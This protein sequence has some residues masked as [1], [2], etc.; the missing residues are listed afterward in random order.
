MNDNGTSNA[1]VG[2]SRHNHYRAFMDC[3][4]YR[5]FASFLCL[6]ASLV[7]APSAF[8]EKTVIQSQTV[9]G[10]NRLAVTRYAMI[11][12]THT[13]PR[14][15]YW[16]LNGGQI[17]QGL[18]QPGATMQM[19]VHLRNGSWT[20]NTVS[21]GRRPVSLTGNDVTVQWGDNIGVSQQPF[22]IGLQ[23][24]EFEVEYG[25]GAGLVGHVLPDLQ[26]SINLATKQIVIVDPLKPDADQDG[27]PDDQD[28]DDDND[29]IPDAQD[30][31]H[32]DYVPPDTDGDGL[33]DDIDD[34]DDGD[35]IPDNQDPHPKV[36]D[37]I[38]DTDGDGQPDWSDPDDDNDGSPDSQDPEPLNPDVTGPNIPPDGSGL[39]TDGDGIPDYRDS[40]DD[41]DG[42][43]DV[44]DRYP[45]DPTNGGGGGGTPDTPN[46]PPVPPSD[47]GGA[48]AMNQITEGPD[49]LPQIKPPSES[50]VNNI[51]EARGKM[52]LKIQNF[53]LLQ[54]GSI[55]RTNTWSQTLT[56]PH[57]GTMNL[58]VDFTKQPFPAIRA[59]IA[60][61]FAMV[62]GNA[63]LK[64]LTI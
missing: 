63:L 5:R 9:N 22:I 24:A 50:V 60:C 25:G 64:R 30:P 11:T 46:I 2:A 45:K 32:P 61:V 35:G 34:D 57:F 4:R 20:G 54:A 53:K 43:S 26:I 16:A 12:W 18:A 13:T 15:F 44:W 8:A 52:A 17:N 59:G 36:K 10:N 42:I 51:D 38:K 27:I 21:S 3:G 31:D 37:E 6:V 39:D 28:P 40:D 48:G 41:N 14:D 7:L 58:T 33:S 55:P 56:M 49:G 29:G 62:L 23:G 19:P 1:S 47:D